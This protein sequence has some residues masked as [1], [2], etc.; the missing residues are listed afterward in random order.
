MFLSLVPLL[1]PA[2]TGASGGVATTAPPPAAAPVS[3]RW[4]FDADP[5]GGS[6]QGFEFAQTGGG[7]SGRWEIL[8]DP[9]KP[10]N[11]VLAQVDT[12]RE[13]DRF[14]LAVA[15]VGAFRDLRLAVRCEMIGGEVDQA[16]G[17][18]FRYRD[19]GNY[20]VTRANA[21]EGNVRLYTVRGGKRRQIASWSGDVAP[22][23][24]H[25]YAVTV[26]GEQ[27]RVSWDG[28]TV[29][30]VRDTVFPDAGRVGLWTKADSV[31]WFDDL[32]VEAP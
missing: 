3:A 4:T 26:Q 6:P 11:R 13:D 16:C 31:T 21:L 10:G 20:Y 23:R 14:P 2:C 7:P 30:D 28:A 5:P 25:D 17:L 12:T 22:G 27:I 24:W 15:S 19:S 32:A 18:V 8:D 9:A 1:L 29:I